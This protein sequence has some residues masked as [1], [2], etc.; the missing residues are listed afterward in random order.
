VGII[1]LGI[2]FNQCGNRADL[3]SLS[4]KKRRTTVKIDLIRALPSS[5]DQGEHF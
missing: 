2:Y 3:H 5:T 4:E 1:D